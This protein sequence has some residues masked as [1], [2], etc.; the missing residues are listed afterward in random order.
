MVEKESIKLKS[1]IKRC[2]FLVPT[3]IDWCI[4]SPSLPTIWTQAR[5][6][7]LIQIKDLI[8]ICGMRSHGHG[9]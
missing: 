7:N 5:S 8:S 4:T 9:I 2:H 1:T 6:K 3:T